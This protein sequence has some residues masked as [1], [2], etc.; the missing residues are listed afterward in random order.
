MNDAASTTVIALAAALFLGMGI[1]GLVT[2]AHLVAPFGL[3]AGTPESRSEMRAV[4]GGFGVTVAAVLAVAVLDTGVL[5]RGVAVAVAAA[6]AGMALD[7][8]V[9]RVAGDRT[10]FLPRLVPLL[11]S[12]GR[13]LRTP[14]PRAIV[15][16]IWPR[17]APDRYRATDRQSASQRAVPSCRTSPRPDGADDRLVTTS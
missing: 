3:R 9:C 7:R 14:R 8:V 13:A 15:A 17:G 5:R 10:G 4:Y 6:L 11:R 12:A 2:R 16:R 1:H